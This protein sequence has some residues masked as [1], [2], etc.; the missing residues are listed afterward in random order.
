MK[1]KAYVVLVMHEPNVGP[2]TLLLADE[3]KDRDEA[4]AR[5][6]A[7]LATKPEWHA[8]VATIAEISPDFRI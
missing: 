5:A 6:K 2:S 3:C 7:F 1:T 8:H 4:E